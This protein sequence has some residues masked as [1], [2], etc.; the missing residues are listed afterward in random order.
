MDE[1]TLEWRQLVEIIPEL[2][3][4]LVSVFSDNFVTRLLETHGELTTVNLNF[5]EALIRRI[6]RLLQFIT[7]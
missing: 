3:K 4:G 5:I 1:S 7:I 6:K 2:K